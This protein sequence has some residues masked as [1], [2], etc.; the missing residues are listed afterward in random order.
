[1]DPFAQL[2]TLIRTDLPRATRAAVSLR[3]KLHQ[4]PEI[5]H[6]EFKT[7]ARLKSE[8]RK[9]GLSIHD[10]GIPTGLWAELDSGR[11][12]PVIAIRTDIDALPVNEETDL[13]FK[14]RRPGYMHAC[15][16]DVHTAVLAGAAG[17]LARHRDYLRGRVKFICQP[18]EEVPPGGARPMIEAGVL[19]E[20]P[21]DAI[22]ALHVDPSLPTGTI[23]VRDGVTMASVYDFNL[24]VIGKGGHAALPHETIDSIAVASQIVSGLQQVISRMV[25]PV[26]PSVISFGLIR[27][28]TVRNAI[29]GETVLEGTAR[30]LDPGLIRRL[31]RLIKKTATNIGR[32]LGARV[33]VESIANYPPLISN[34]RVNRFISESYYAV[35]YRGKIHEI[36]QVLGGEDFSYYLE[37]VPGAMFRLGVRNKRIGADKPWHHPCFIADENAIPVGIATMAATVA[38]LLHHWHGGRR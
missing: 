13:P 11:E 24:R 26:K 36:P 18:A 15:G 19:E 32:G 25:D 27:G 1:M 20:P 22:A 17:I 8:L 31:P 35:G 29:A 21:V 16:H 30:S 4:Y 3:R 10:A 2:L 34:S 5:G 12:G 37:K 9:T 23:G 14:S 6:Q 38:N 33:E 7:T 28:G